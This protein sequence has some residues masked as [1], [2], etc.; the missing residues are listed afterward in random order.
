VPETSRGNV[1]ANKKQSPRERVKTVLE[2]GF[3]AEG[4]VLRPLGPK[5]DHRGLV[6]M[7]MSCSRNH[8]RAGSASVLGCH[9]IR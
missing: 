5:R 3:C 1:V 7:S 4:R 9:A 6:T 8:M 2:V